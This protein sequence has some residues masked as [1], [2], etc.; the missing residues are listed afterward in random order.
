MHHLVS[1]TKD[2]YVRRPSK[3]FIDAGGCFPSEV[4]APESRRFDARGAPPSPDRQAK[5]GPTMCVR[6]TEEKERAVDVN[7]MVQTDLR[8]FLAEVEA[9]G[10]L[11]TVQGAHWDKEMGAVTE[12]L[13]RA[14]GRQVAD[15]AVRQHP[16]LQEGLPLRLRHARLAVPP[17][18]RAGDGRRQG[19]Q[20]ARHAERLPKAKMRGAR[21]GSRR[22]WST[23]ARSRRTSTAT[24]TSTC[25]KFPVPI[26]HELDGGRYIGTACGVVTRDPDSGRINVGTYRVQVI[27]GKTLRLLH[28][29]RQAGPHPSR[30]VLRQRASRA[31]S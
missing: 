27:D 17:R 9:A 22:A 7:R 3:T 12:V 10:E 2:C 25:S 5:C 1:G 15:A 23:T 14:E 11:K 30:Q 13:Y 18:A 19:R 6:E 24:A 28:L 21:A 8:D 4:P 26:H 16:R 20:P 29:Q 31:R